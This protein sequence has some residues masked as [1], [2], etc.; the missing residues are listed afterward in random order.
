M[1]CP[2]CG[3]VDTG[4][5]DSR[6]TKEKTAIRRRRQCLGCA[7]RFTTYETTPG[8]LM[9]LLL[10]THAGKGASMKSSDAVL[11]FMSEALK[12]LSAECE[13][14]IGGVGKFAPAKRVKRKVK[15]KAKRKVPP[16]KKT[17]TK[18][19]GPAKK[20]VTSKSKRSK[21][22]SDTAK[23]LQVI[24]G[25]K[26]GADIPRLKKKTGFADSKIRAIVYRASKEGKIKRVRRGVYISQ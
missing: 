7:G 2:F 15:A 20:T 18:K 11:S 4:V 9:L 13:R 17:L 1:E 3:K 21:K 19:K 5:I 16:K 23:V 22:L 25:Y 12:G 24:R 8:Q 26:K 14:L 6:P 10:K